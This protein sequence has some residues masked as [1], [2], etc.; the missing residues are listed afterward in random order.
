MDVKIEK[1]GERELCDYLSGCIDGGHKKKGFGLLECLEPESLKERTGRTYIYGVAYR[2]NSRDKGL[3]INYCPFCG[4][5]P[6]RVHAAAS[7]GE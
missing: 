1:C 7:K 3:V 2:T 5:K 4:G 6:G